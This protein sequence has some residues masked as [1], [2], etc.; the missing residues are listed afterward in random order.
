[1][2]S[3]DECLFDELTICTP[4]SFG[5]RLVADAEQLRRAHESVVDDT[6]GMSAS[7]L[8]ESPDDS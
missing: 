6:V 2:P 5:K 4:E 7:A 1:V 8:S 3:Y